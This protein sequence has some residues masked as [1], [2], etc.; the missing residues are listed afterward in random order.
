[1]IQTCNLNKLKAYWKKKPTHLKTIIFRTHVPILLVFEDG[2]KDRNIPRNLIFLKNYNSSVYDCTQNSYLL[3]IFDYINLHKQFKARNSFYVNS[4][5]KHRYRCFQTENICIY[6]KH[7]EIY[8]LPY[9]NAHMKNT[10]TVL[11]QII[12]IF[13]A[14]NCCIC[15]QEQDG[16]TPRTTKC[17]NFHLWEPKF[18]ECIVRW[19]VTVFFTQLPLCFLQSSGWERHNLPVVPTQRF[20]FL[21]EFL[22]LFSI[23]LGDH[24]QSLT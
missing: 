3:W 19:P 23:A 14:G 11:P 24:V 7:M 9:E 22:S 12:F 1:M 6:G 16:H 8:I 4:L 18:P 15:H 2:K 20:W 13:L 10:S 17:K 5:F 21:L